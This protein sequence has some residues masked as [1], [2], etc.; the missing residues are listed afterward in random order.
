MKPIDL[1][2]LIFVI[3]DF[4]YITECVGSNKNIESFQIKYFTIYTG[5]N[6]NVSVNE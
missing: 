6:L 1:L 2:L 4:I 3:T 5:L